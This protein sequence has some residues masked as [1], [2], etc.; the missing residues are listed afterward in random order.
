MVRFGEIFILGLDISVGDDQGTSKGKC[1][2]SCRVELELQ[3]CPGPQ[4]RNSKPMGLKHL[5]QFR[6]CGEKDFPHIT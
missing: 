3:P 4:D 5:R 2:E 1:S 6:Y